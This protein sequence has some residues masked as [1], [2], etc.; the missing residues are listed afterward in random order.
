MVLLVVAEG[1]VC[2]R[3]GIL[4]VGVEF[5]I[6]DEPVVLYLP[7]VF[8]LA[9]PYLKLIILRGQYNF[10]L[11][12]A[13]TTYAG[14]SYDVWLATQMA[15]GEDLLGSN[16]GVLWLLLLAFAHIG[17]FGLCTWGYEEKGE[18]VRRWSV[19]LSVVVG[20]AAFAAPVLVA[21]SMNS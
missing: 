14:L 17:L 18:L 21:S 4:D 2:W 8:A 15:R 7:V 19:P 20:A 13:D 1:A 5:G 9:I 12:P 11:L 6:G 16:A 3:A 10:G